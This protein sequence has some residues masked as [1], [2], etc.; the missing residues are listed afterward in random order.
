MQDIITIQA[1]AS[2]AIDKAQDIS[3]LELIRVDFLG[4][5]GKLTEI[6][7]GLAGLSAEEKP[8]AGQLVNQAKREISTLIETKMLEL[9]EKQLLEIILRANRRNTP[10]A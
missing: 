8:K 3:I 1:Q 4:K 9:K 10:W 2:E 7:K 5:K 6:L